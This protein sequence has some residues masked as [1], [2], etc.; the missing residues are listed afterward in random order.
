MED[1][2]LGPVRMQNLIGRLSAAPGRVRSTGPS[3]G[4]HNAEILCGLIGYG[5]AETRRMAGEGVISSA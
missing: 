1:P 5:E 3:L 2:V 4:E